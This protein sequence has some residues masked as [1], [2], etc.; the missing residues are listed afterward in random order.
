MIS[1]TV[2]IF[3]PTLFVFGNISS[4]LFVQVLMKDKDNKNFE[5]ECL[6]TMYESTMSRETY[7]LFKC[8]ILCANENDVKGVSG[9]WFRYSCDIQPDFSLLIRYE[10]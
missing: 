6:K 1:L 3:S 7:G 9:H 4:L 5:S 2:V 8:N 10:Q